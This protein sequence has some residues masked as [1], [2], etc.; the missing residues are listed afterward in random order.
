MKFGRNYKLTIETNP[1]ITGTPLAPPPGQTEPGNSST[2]QPSSSPS[3]KALIIESPL[4]IRFN[5][6]RGGNSRPHMDLQIYNLNESSREAIRHDRFSSRKLQKIVLEAGYDNLS[7]VFRGDIF[8]A[9]STRENETN[10]VT[11]IDAR[12]GGFDISNTKTYQTIQKNTTYKDVFMA[13]IAQFPTLK[14]GSIGSIDGTAL[15][16]VVLVGNTW[17]LANKVC[18]GNCFVDLGEIHVLKSGEAIVRKDLQTKGPASVPIIGPETGLLGTPQ[19][20][21]AFISVKTLFEPTIIIGE[22][23][24]LKS[25][26]MPFYDGQYKVIGINH[27]GIISGAINGTCYTTF[28]LVK[29][30][31]LNGGFK[32]VT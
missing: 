7:V 8:S 5:I 27:N 12:D 24:Q 30:D 21:D 10:I 16:P 1:I 3:N 13:L 29:S 31:Q 2:A 22:I 14:P 32:A 9:S 15:R 11:Y 4:T 19:R 25:Q 6:T 17:Q 26:V 18:N 23:V 28:S 20:E